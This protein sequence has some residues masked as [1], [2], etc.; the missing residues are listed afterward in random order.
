[1]DR[2][3]HILYLIPGFVVGLTFH[4][5]CHAW[6]ANRLGD[7][8]ARIHGRLT[9]NPL[10][11][12]DL[13]GSLMLVF[14][15]FGW[16]KPVPVNVYNLQSPRRDM[17]LIASAGPAA[18][19]ILAIAVSLLAHGLI[20]AGVVGASS[21]SALLLL[22]LVQSVW[23]NV[24]LAVFNLI[25]IP[26]LDGSRILAGV[27]PEEWNYGYEQFEKYGPFMLF[28]LILLANVTGV[29]VLGRIV[30]PVAQPVFNLVM[31]EWLFH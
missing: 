17:A 12:L 25:P 6:T 13:I 28:G 21:A 30:M 18:N 7:P 27:V 31:G 20:A 4:E 3:S 24:I 1:L 29:S 11:H 5:F 14:A 10:A 8:T 2:Y 22:I 16:A 15:G 23:I 19:L 26:P 9:L